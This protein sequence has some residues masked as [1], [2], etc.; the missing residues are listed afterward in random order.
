MHSG[1]IDKLTALHVL[2]RL[3]Q[4]RHASSGPQVVCFVELD[5]SILDV[6]EDSKLAEADELF[7]KSIIATAD[8]SDESEGDDLDPISAISW[9]DTGCGMEL[10]VIAESELIATEKDVEDNALQPFADHS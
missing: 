2:K 5:V 6:E 10:V 7:D 3:D 8:G 4:N 1:T 9:Q